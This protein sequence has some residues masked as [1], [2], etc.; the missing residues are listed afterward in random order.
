[1]DRSIDRLK[2]T[3][4]LNM[5]CCIGVVVCCMFHFPCCMVYVLWCMLYAYSTLQHNIAQY[6]TYAAACCISRCGVRY[7]VVYCGNAVV[8]EVVTV[9]SYYNFKLP[10]LLATNKM[11]P[12]NNTNYNWSYHNYKLP[13]RC[14]QNMY[15]KSASTTTNP[16]AATCTRYDVFIQRPIL[17]TTTNQRGWCGETFVSILAQLQ[18]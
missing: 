11:P 12:I 7:V 18:S 9:I 16:A 14:L 10:Q 5:V 2:Y 17:Y 4:Q 3:V 13:R 8:L 1:M 6:A 15:Q